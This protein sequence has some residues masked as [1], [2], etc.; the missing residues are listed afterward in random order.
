MSPGEKAVFVH[1]T[2][3]GLEETELEVHGT[4]E[5]AMAQKKI[6]AKIMELLNHPDLSEG[7][8]R[9]LVIGKIPETQ[10]VMVL[11][12]TYGV[13]EKNGKKYYNI[14]PIGPLIKPDDRA[15]RAKAM[16]TEIV[17]AAYSGGSVFFPEIISKKKK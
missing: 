3:K 13:G 6:P 4:L 14:G 10:H 9:G 1:R 8:V 11:G 7:M 16:I 2:E 12:S 17:R 5:H 15:E